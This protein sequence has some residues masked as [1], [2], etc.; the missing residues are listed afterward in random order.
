[1]VPSH[2]R[3]QALM[4]DAHEAIVGDVAGPVKAALRVYGDAWDRLERETASKVRKWY[5]LPPRLHSTVILADRKILLSE[6]RD[7]FTPE[8]AAAARAMG[9]AVEKPGH[10]PK[11]FPRTQQESYEDF[12][13]AFGRWGNGVGV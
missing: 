2:M 8:A 1:M 11:I 3:F 12:L 10:T 4:H 7:I 13:E 6:M 5:G 9:I